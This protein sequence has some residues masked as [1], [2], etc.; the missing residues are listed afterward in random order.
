MQATYKNHHIIPKTKKLSTRKY[1]HLRSG[2]IAKPEN[3]LGFSEYR[4]QKN[5]GFFGGHRKTAKPE[6]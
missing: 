1:R 6:Q 2:K 4:N 5:G 3:P